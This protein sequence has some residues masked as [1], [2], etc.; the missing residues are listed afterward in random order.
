MIKEITIHTKIYNILYYININIFFIFSVKYFY[1][2]ITFLWKCVVGSF[3]Y[4]ISSLFQP[5]LISGKSNIASFTLI[6]L[7][8]AE[9]IQLQFELY[10]NI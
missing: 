2:I 5:F 1:E 9:S 8:G 6:V 7:N 10:W 3:V 4:D